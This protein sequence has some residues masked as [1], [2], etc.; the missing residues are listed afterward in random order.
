MI[1]S[2]LAKGTLMSIII[3]KVINGYF[4]M[5]DQYAENHNLLSNEQ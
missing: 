2:C 3:S 5:I 1:P 4:H